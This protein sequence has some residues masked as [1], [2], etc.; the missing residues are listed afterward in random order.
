M[1]RIFSLIL[2][3]L[4]VLAIVPVS[5]L[6][7][8]AE[9]EVVTLYNN[10]FDTAMNPNGGTPSSCSREDYASFGDGKGMTV[11][12]NGSWTEPVTLDNN[13]GE[14]VVEMYFYNNNFTSGTTLSINGVALFGGDASGIPTIGGVAQGTNNRQWRLGTLT[15]TISDPSTGVA[16]VKYVDQYTNTYTGNVT[17]GA[18]EDKIDLKIGSFGNSF[19]VDYVKVTQ[20]HVEDQPDQ[21]E[22]PGDDVIPTDLFSTGAKDYAGWTNGTFDTYTVTAN[23]TDG[24]ITVTLSFVRA[25]WQGKAKV[26][27]INGKT[28]LFGN[29]SSGNGA[30]SLA[31]DA[32]VYGNW[33]TDCVITV[34]IDPLTGDATV[35]DN[36]S[37]STTTNVGVI[38]ETFNVVVGQENANS[39]SLKGL[40][41]TQEIGVKA[42]TT[43]REEYR[44]YKNDFTTIS[45]DIINQ[46]G[47]VSS[48]VVEGALKVEPTDTNQ[49]NVGGADY[50]ANSVM[51]FKAMVPEL[52]EED[53]DVLLLCDRATRNYFIRVT[54]GEGKNVVVM[55]TGNAQPDVVEV[56]AGEWFEVTII[57][58]ESG[59]TV[60]VNNQFMG[61]T[62]V[63]FAGRTMNWGVF[64]F[65][66][67]DTDNTVAYYVDDIEIN[68]TADDAFVKV[69][70][71][72]KTVVDGE[73]KYNVRFIASI[74]DIYGAQE[75]IGFEVTCAEHSKNW[76]GVTTTVY[77]SIT[78]NFGTESV[79]A[80]ELGGKYVTAYAITGIPAELGEVELVVKPYVTIN[81]V[82]VYG[83]T[84][85]VVVNPV[86][87]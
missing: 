39:W 29:G 14:I 3:T 42:D 82:K 70:G 59:S 22:Q 28:V 56:E 5:V 6:M 61:T 17:V 81:G 18:I 36:A 80:E 37:H 79:T 52:L 8:S 64:H 44:Y 83:T 38:G 34:V 49:W 32:T 87:E 4:M 73:G 20:V 23:G 67:A 71:Y 27:T 48:T 40:T 16:N 46:S 63:T 41:V 75:N 30:Y 65:N 12:G 33:P 43:T 31:D 13:S 78:A 76:N 10:E 51:S 57:M 11:Y 35:S 7:V 58:T 66:Y 21:P 68:T 2:C 25:N 74:A 85:T 15:V 55:N 86:A 45:G 47:A 24:D 26:L 72:Q 84:V 60:F 19:K 77:N 54:A 53:N 9:G 50:P 62:S 69:T 1:K